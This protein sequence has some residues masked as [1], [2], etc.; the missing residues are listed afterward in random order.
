[1]DDNNKKIAH[2]RDEIKSYMA[3]RKA[4]IIGVVVGILITIGGML[5]DGSESDA[6]IFIIVHDYGDWIVY[7][8]GIGIIG[9]A[10]AILM[11]YWISKVDAKIREVENERKL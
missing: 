9:I 1:M 4:S 8:V 6:G 11:S 10:G 2:Y 7:G 5:L 3:L